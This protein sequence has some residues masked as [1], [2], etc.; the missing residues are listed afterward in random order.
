MLLLIVLLLLAN[1]NTSF[2]QETIV[3]ARGEGNYYCVRIP[4][5]MTTVKGTLIAFGEARMFTCQDNTDIDI[6]YKRSLDNGR[7]W[8]DLQVLYRGNSSGENFNWVGNF[9]PVQLKYNQRILVPFC[10][11]NLVPMQTYSDDDGLT[12]APPQIIPNIAK[13][14]WKW[15][16]LG[17]PSGILLQSNR[18]LVPGDYSIN[19]NV[20]A[21]SLSTGFVMLNDFNGQ[22]DKWYLGGEYNLDNYYPNEGQAVELLPSNNSIFINARSHTTKR[23][24]AYSTNGGITF[25]KVTVLNTLVEPLHG[26]EGS[27]LYHPSTRQLFYSGLAVTSNIRANLSL[28]ISNDNGET[29]SYIKAICPGPSGYSSLTTLTDQSIGMLYEKGSTMGSPDSL[30]FTI[31]YNQTKKGTI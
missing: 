27:T 24:G 15:L 22:I 28:H 13:P 10:R 21:G 3:F 2:E 25:D 18:I 14:N 11:N 19:S 8:S 26:C 31:V 17:P 6:V 12:F 20:R 1:S 23:I 7:T 30:T 16:A 9:A 29:W 4:S 5:V